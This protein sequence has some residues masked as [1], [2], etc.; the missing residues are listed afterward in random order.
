LRKN[1]SDSYLVYFHHHLYQDIFRVLNYTHIIWDWNGTVINDAHLCVRIVNCIL[2]KYSKP[3]ISLTFYLD[4]FRF[5]AKE[6]YLLL[7]LPIDHI[8]YCKISNSFISAYRENY[9]ECKL[10]SGIYNLIYEFD[11]EGISQSIL[12]AGHPDDL[13]SFLKYFDLSSIFKIVSGVS[14]FRAEG[15]QHI[16]KKHLEKISFP[17][18][19]ILYIGDTIHDHQISELLDVDCLIVSHGH[20]SKSV[21]KSTCKKIVDSSFEIKDWVLD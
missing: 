10:H 3:E 14:N 6:F 15:K 8:N 17:K 13:D 19:K 21:L 4:K 2:R 18:S 11:R 12:S 9:R 5:P 16:A 1:L 20:N 7:G